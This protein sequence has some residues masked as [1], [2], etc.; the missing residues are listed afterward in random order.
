MDVREE[1]GEAFGLDEEANG[2]VGEG[3]GVVEDEKGFWAG[4]AEVGKVELK[5]LLPRFE[6]M[7]SFLDDS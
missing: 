1:K 2:L 4:V 7:W 3:F 6:G 5:R